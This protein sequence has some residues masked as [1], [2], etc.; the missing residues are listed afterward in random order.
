M[1]MRLP[2]GV[3][4]AG[5][6]AVIAMLVW[7]ASTDNWTARDWHTPAA[8]SVD[9]LETLARFRLAEER[10]LALLWDPTAPRLGAP[11]QAD[12][13]PYPLPDA[14]WYAIAGRAAERIGLVPA[15][16]LMLLLAQVAA[17]LS[18]Y[19]C[20][21]VLRHGMLPA[22]GAALLF[23]FSFSICHRGLSH[24]SFA[25]A[26]AVPPAL[27][28]VWLV[29]GSR[30]LI[31]TA[32][33]RA[34]VIG[35]GLLTGLGNPY[36]IYL[37][38]VLL[39]TAGLVQLATARRRANLLTG[40]AAG[41]ACLLVFALTNLPLLRA[42]V[43]ASA[44]DLFARN[45]AA[46]TIYGLRWIDLVVPPAQHRVAALAEIGRA[47]ERTATG[48][49]FAPY[50]G[51]VGTVALL[52]VVVLAVTRWL[53][54]RPRPLR[55]GHAAWAGAILA[56]ALVGGINHWLAQAGFDYF[57]A[58][59]RYSIHLL[60][61]ALFGLSALVSR[62]PRGRGMTAA[63][64]AV[65]LLGL[66][67]Q[68][69]R[70]LGEESRQQ[71]R[72]LMTTDRA[73]ATRLESSLPANSAIFQLPV[74]HFP[75]QGPLGR[76][77]DYELLRPYLFSQTLRW[78]HGGLR[79]SALLPW[80]RNVA[81]LPPA[82][83]VRELERAGFAALAVRS[84][85]FAD[86]AAV[87]REQL[88]QLG[89]PVLLAEGEFVVFRL[90]PTEPLRAPAEEDPLRFPSWDAGPPP[91]D[92]PAVL[93]GDGWHDVEKSTTRIWRWALPVATLRLANPAPEP[94]RVRLTALLT[95][96]A[97]TALTWSCGESGG[98]IE[99]P[100]NSAQ[101]ITLELTLAPGLNLLALR[102][103]LTPRRAGPD[104]PRQIAFQLAELRLE[105]AP[106]ESQ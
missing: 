88:P 12:W 80:Q 24:H 93:L 101:A 98:R 95:T 68:T 18:F 78:S 38:G 53:R 21:R 50:L 72:A 90:Q 58:S 39:A 60:A 104:D 89:R 43:T 94:R 74:A 13:S 99:R 10:G 19:F 9:A 70:P 106:A 59:N 20:A 45:A 26:F 79:S 2:M 83:L 61:V 96:V 54:R 6:L 47:H 69:P 22:A 15:S 102:T 46:T 49:L 71:L 91:T 29:A 4:R 44:T 100:D 7:L 32:R 8:Y 82:L 66:W 73:I 67:D 28:A 64:F 85:A 42:A 41:G 37:F 75:E 40:A 17:V 76:M 33:G 55:P 63:V 27:L 77:L 92:R 65:T 3:F 5:A 105:P 11:A 35:G 16:N 31:T 81:Q 30:R 86:E 52:L 25:L 84:D 51:V 48:E 34:L 23:G 87:L 14:F 62:L 57:R 97:P 1:N 36:F 56:F 103:G